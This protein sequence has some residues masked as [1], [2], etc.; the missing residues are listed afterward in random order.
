M[1]ENR[2]IRSELDV[3]LE[4]RR[5]V[6]E[7]RLQGF[8]IDQIAEKIG[9]SPHTVARDLDETRLLYAELIGRDYE[10]WRQLELARL[11]ALDVRNSVL[12]DD[13]D[14]RTVS[15]AIQNALAISAAR[16]RL[17]GLDAPRRQEIDT[18]NEISIRIVEEDDD[19][20]ES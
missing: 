15:A 19:A 6:W 1:P 13:H 14:P 5:R 2:Q 12:L 20:D 3:A 4:R 10:T 8:S 7:L 18:T 11:D 16:R 17:L 9:C